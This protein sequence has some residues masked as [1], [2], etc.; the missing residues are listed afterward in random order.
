MRSI[1]KLAVVAITGV[2]LSLPAFASTADFTGTLSTFTGSGAGIPTTTT[3]LSGS[4]NVNFASN[5]GS[6]TIPSAAFIANATSVVGWTSSAAAN[7]IYTIRTVTNSSNLPGVFNK[8]LSCGAYTGTMGSGSAVLVE[9]GIVPLPMVFGSLVL[10][11][12]VGSAGTVTAMAAVL[13]NAV[14]VTVI[15]GGWTTGMI[16]VSD[17]TGGVSQ[18]TATVA[19]TATTTGTN[20]LTAGGGQITL[21]TPFLVLIRGASMENRAGYAVLSLNFSN[22][23]PE[24]GTLLLLGSGVA[25][26]AFLGRRKRA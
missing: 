15:A 2:V 23:I 26:L 14:T 22:K 20:S 3:P 5:G 4:G 11:V 9:L 13:A 21:V 25:G 1:I 18:P 8:C 7:S 16:T 10:P 12:N 6:F 19:S 24:P 17:Q